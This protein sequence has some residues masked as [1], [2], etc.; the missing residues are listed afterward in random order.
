VAVL[1]VVHSSAWSA[2]DFKISQQGGSSTIN[3]SL[4]GSASSTRERVLEIDDAVGFRTPVWKHGFRGNHFQFDSFEAGLAPG[5]DYWVRMDGAAPVHPLRLT[6]ETTLGTY[7]NCAELRTN[8]EVIGRP[9]VERRSNAHWEAD[10]GL[11][12]PVP[13]SLPS[14]LNIYF[15]E[16]FLR[17]GL[18]WAQSCNDLAFYDEASQYYLAMLQQT[19]RLSVAERRLPTDPEVKSVMMAGRTFPAGDQLVGDLDLGQAQWLY[20]AAKLERLVSLLPPG[21]RSATMRQFT[22]EFTHFLVEEQL[23]RFLYRPA[24]PAPGGGPTISRLAVWDLTLRGVQGRKSSDTAM[25]DVD[26]WLL[27]SSAEVLG[28]HANDPALVSV[29]DDSVEQ[30]HSALETGIQVFQSKRTLYPDTVDFQ[31]RRVGSA[32]Y[33]NGDYDGYDDLAFSA[34]SGPDFPTPNKKR[35]LLNID[36]DTSHAYRL[37]VFLRALY[38]NRKATGSAF[39]SLQEMKLLT[40]QYVYRVFNGDFARPLFSNYLDGNDTWFRVDLAKGSGYPPS[41]FCD[42]MVPNRPC[43]APGNVVGWGLLAYVNP[44]LAK[45]EKSL[46][47]LGFQTDEDAR[48]FR[49][50]HYT[51][52]W[53]YGQVSQNG[54]TVYGDTLSFVIA[55]NSSMLP[56]SP[57]R[58]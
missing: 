5:I 23:L 56:A 11:W 41:R 21:R 3:V 48:Q 46:I 27:A 44:D 35:A 9:I 16:L 6:E 57:R 22:S 4:T 17:S 32:T 1:V 29:S 34:V 45:L 18:Q 40:N 47:E 50:R 58:P 2:A 53:P 37:P 26:L 55:D 54:K 51:Y 14:G 10:K 15:V 8:W 19:V 25:S 20:P 30:L 7:A 28:A 12:V 24:R 31:Q 36:W 39:P 33:F 13:P 49:D 52:T 42:D 43:E 38:D